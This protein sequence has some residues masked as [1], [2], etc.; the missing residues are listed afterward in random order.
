MTHAARLGSRIETT[1]TETVLA[2][3]TA[4]VKALSIPAGP[5]AGVSPIQP[6]IALGI[7][8]KAGT[9]FQ[10]AVRCQ[11]RE[12]MTGKE[13]EQIRKNAKDEVDVRY[14]G[15]VTK[16]GVP[17]TQQRHRPLQIGI[18]VGHVKV[19]AGTLGAFVKKRGAEDA[20]ILSNNHVLANENRAKTGDAIV[21]AGTIDAGT[22]PEDRI[23][24]L[25]GGDLRAPAADRSG[26]PEGGLGQRVRSG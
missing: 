4:Q 3:F 17:W 5:V 25:A 18:S 8:R 9:E 16:R 26:C 6:S 12:L 10:I 22:D 23:A 21:Q 14:I 2:P 7:G 24:T 1:L 13:V 15:P 19:T 20:L 11:R